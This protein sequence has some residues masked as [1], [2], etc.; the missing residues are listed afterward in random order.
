MP[1]IQHN[2]V[3]MIQS[4]SAT[5]TLKRNLRHHLRVP[6]RVPATVQTREGQPVSAEVANISRAGVMLECDRQTLELIHPKAMT[7]NPG[8]PLETALAFTIPSQTGGKVAINCTCHIIYARR[9]SRDV[10]H[11]G[12][13]FKDLEEH[14]APHLEHYIEAHRE[15]TPHGED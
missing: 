1:D 10:F 13:E 4:S 9:L 5:M 11:V 15:I 14:L 2:I 7:A 12:L 3:T 8:S 6:I